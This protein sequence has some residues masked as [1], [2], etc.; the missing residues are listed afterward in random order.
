[1]NVWI[2]L[3]VKIPQ[4]GEK[5]LEGTEFKGCLVVESYKHYEHMIS[6]G[7]KDTVP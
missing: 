3:H 4:Q 1:M 7:K 6:H 5:L 2:T